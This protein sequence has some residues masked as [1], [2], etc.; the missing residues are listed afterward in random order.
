VLAKGHTYTITGT[1]FNGMSQAN[2]YGD[3][4]QSATNYPIVRLTNGT[5]QVSYLRSVNFS[6][7]GVA[8]G[9]ATV[10]AEIEVPTR[11]GDGSWDL[12]VIANG[13]A[14]APKPVQVTGNPA[15]P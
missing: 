4:R 8:T 14:S 12:A 13:I 2:S 1:Q 9:D 7:M 11:I 6:G 3:D 10:A 15:M 5:G